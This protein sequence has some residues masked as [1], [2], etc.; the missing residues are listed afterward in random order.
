MGV[1]EDFE[2]GSDIIRLWW[3][4]FG[5]WIWRGKSE[6]ETLQEGVAIIQRKSAAKERSGQGN[7]GCVGR[8]CPATQDEP[9]KF[10]NA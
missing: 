3:L 2:P 10:R 5:A 1:V 4:L 8:G 7:A 6:S 9:T